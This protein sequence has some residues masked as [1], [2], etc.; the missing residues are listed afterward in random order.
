MMQYD[1][2]IEFPEAGTNNGDDNVNHGVT[3]EDSLTNNQIAVGLMYNLV[4]G[5]AV[6]VRLLVLSFDR[7][8]NETT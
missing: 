3:W 5:A 7:M 6:L 2:D 4:F 8:I 1:G